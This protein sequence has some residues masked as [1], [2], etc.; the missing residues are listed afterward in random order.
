MADGRRRDR[1]VVERL[2]HAVGA[3]RHP[4]V[5]LVGALPAFV[6][7]N[8]RAQAT[9]LRSPAIWLSF[10]AMARA[11]P[12]GR[13]Q[14]EWARPQR[15]ARRFRRVQPLALQREQPA[16]LSIEFELDRQC[17]FRLQLVARSILAEAHAAVQSRVLWVPEPQQPPRLDHRAFGSSSFRP[18][19]ISSGHG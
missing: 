11:P 12:A 6:A 5:E 7:P 13:V 1:R 16:L 9:K 19:L 18:P 4:A 8:L 17:G 3:V 2:H 10:P 14:N 15:V